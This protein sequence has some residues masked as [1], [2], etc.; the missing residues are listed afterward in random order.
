MDYYMKDLADGDVA[1]AVVN[2]NDSETAYTVTLSDYEALDASAS[3]S[4]RNLI[5]RTDAGTL[6]ASSALTGSLAAHGTFIVRLKKQ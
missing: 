5:G 1:V 3:Y 6:S 2:L 4:A